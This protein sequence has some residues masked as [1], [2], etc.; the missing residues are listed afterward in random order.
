RERAAAL[1]PL[2]VALDAHFGGDELVRSVHAV[3]AADFRVRAPLAD[4]YAKLQAAKAPIDE[5]KERDFLDTLRRSA[6]P[7]ILLGA[8]LLTRSPPAHAD[9]IRALAR[10]APS[11]WFEARAALESARADES[12]GALLDAR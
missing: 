4:G 7:D 5:A 3:E 10:R 11:P 8:L 9:E 6:Q 12:R 2:A 1:L